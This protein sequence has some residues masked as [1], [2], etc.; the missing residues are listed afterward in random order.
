[1]DAKLIGML[2][3]GDYL[4]DKATKD[5]N[6]DQARHQGGDVAN[7]ILWIAGHIANSRFGALKLLGVEAGS[8]LGDG[9]TRGA[10]YDAGADYPSLSTIR[11]AWQRASEQLVAKLESMDEAALQ[12]DSGSEWPHGDNSL[13]GALHFLAWHESYHCGQLGQIR[14]SLDLEGLV[15]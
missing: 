15:G 7:P 8:D 2:K 3:L 4:F 12:Q 13:S 11:E 5:L 1:M 6:E 10:Q 14:R 9:F